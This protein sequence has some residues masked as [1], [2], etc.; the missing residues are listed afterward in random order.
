MLYTVPIK[1]LLLL[2]CSD[3]TILIKEVEESAFGLLQGRVGASFEVSQ[4]GKNPLLEFFGIFDRSAESLKSE[5]KTS[6]NVSAGHVEKVVPCRV[7][8]SVCEKDDRHWQ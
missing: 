7:L 5:S 6:D 8:E 3:A 1:H 4:V 2:L